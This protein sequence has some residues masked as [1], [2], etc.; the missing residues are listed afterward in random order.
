MFSFVVC[1]F[2]VYMLLVLCMCVCM[3]SGK[4]ERPWPITGGEI[5]NQSINQFYTVKST[6]Y[7]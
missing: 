1:V 5:I 7:L 4:E 2:L 6:Q 3:L